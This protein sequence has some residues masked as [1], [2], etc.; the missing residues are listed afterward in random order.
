MGDT[1]WVEVRECP[2]RDTASDSSI[3]LRLIDNLDALAVTLNVSKLSSFFDYSELNRAYSYLD[4]QLSPAE[5][6]RIAEE[7]SM[8][9]GRTIG[10]WF[11]SESGELSVRTLRRHLIENFTDL[12][13]VPDE[14]TDHWPSKLLEELE[15]TE[16]VLKK[17]VA[18]QRPFRF[19]VVD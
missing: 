3:M 11:K 5:K 19:L 14:S 16:T 8:D 17:A 15:F 7:F 10:D 12:Q 1:L 2:L 4:L 13:F 6:E 18:E 9:Q